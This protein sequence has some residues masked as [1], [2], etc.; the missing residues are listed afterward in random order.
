MS[1]RVLRLLMR[2]ASTLTIA[3]MQKA[4]LYRTE[5]RASGTTNET[6]V[7]TNR[8]AKVFF[9]CIFV[10]GDPTS[11]QIL[12]YA[13]Y[14]GCW[15]IVACLSSDYNG[16]PFS[17]CYAIDPVTGQELDIDVHLNFTPEDMASISAGEKVDYSKMEKALSPL[18]ETYMERATGASI[19][20]AAEDAEEF[21]LA[22]SGVQPGEVLS[23]EQIANL[24]GLAWQRLAPFLLHLYSSRTFSLED[25]RNIAIKE[26]WSQSD[27][28]ECG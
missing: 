14:F 22:N 5:S 8:P 28:I 26:G 6:D 13:E 2:L 27:E 3:N 24:I 4:I 25:L 17:C 1:N 16:D 9:H 15:R 12:A 21:A 7:V 23:D 20:H 19:A 11:G 10:S 18:V